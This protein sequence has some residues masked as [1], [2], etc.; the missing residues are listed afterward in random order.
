[1]GIESIEQSQL[2]DDDHVLHVQS[3]LVPSPPV[4]DD[5]VDG[6][7][8]GTKRVREEDSI[9]SQRVVRRMEGNPPVDYGDIGDVLP[10]GGSGPFRLRGKSFHLTYRGHV[11]KDKLFRVVGGESG[12]EYWSVV[13]EHGTHREDGE[14][15]YAHTHFYFRS[16]TR[17]QRRC[18]RAFDIEGTHPHIQKVS[19]QEHE[20]RI[21][22]EYHRKEPIQLWQSSQA[23]KDP[24][25]QRDFKRLRESIHR[26]S[27]LEACMSL[28]IEIQSVADVNLIRNEHEPP[29]PEESDYT[30]DDFSLKINW[31]KTTEQGLEEV[32]AIMLY[33]PSGLGKTERAISLFKRPLLVRS[34][35][36]A[37]DFHPDRY[38]GIVFD[39]VN[40]AHLTPEEKIHL[41]DSKHQGVVKCRYKNGILPRGT[42]RIFTTN[43][44]PHDFFIGGSTANEDQVIAIMRRVKIYHVA[45]HTFNHN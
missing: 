36:A 12:L 45:S 9:L 1:V 4:D 43:R 37:R 23:P 30:E 25:L 6:S 21:Y 13:W 2:A 17:L 28:G 15:P 16:R 38:D 3:P 40:L 7:G 31:M 42:K 39:D 8:R 19:T 35:D 5:N 34:L 33:G 18:A 11:D 44:V 26:G 29:A 14:Q 10:T 22:Y 24:A 20:A 32:D 27:L 41:L